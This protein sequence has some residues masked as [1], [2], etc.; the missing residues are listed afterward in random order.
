MTKPPV[1]LR[2]EDL[3]KEPYASILCYP[4]SEPEEVNKR[5]AELKK[6]GVTK[7]KFEDLGHTAGLPVVGK[8]YVGVVIVAYIGDKEYALKIRRTDTGR[9]DLNHEG[10]ML[11]KANS[12]GVGPTLISAS[13]NFMIS[14]FIGGGTLEMWMSNNKDANKI[15][16]VLTDV[17]EQC[18][19]LD[20]A[21][22]DHGE[23]SKAHKHILMDND[24]KPFMIDFE[25]ASTERR[26][27]NV[28]AIC[29]YLFLSNSAV[30]KIITEVMGQRNKQEITN[31]VQEYK[32]RPSEDTFAD[33]LRISL[34]AAVS[35]D[36]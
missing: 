35:K 15:R 12:A 10:E 22:I 8:G 2:I 26:T 21:G 32:R 14:T 4:R 17:M 36:G 24:G 33:L 1:T 29:Q 25:T 30:S 6:L 16:S 7:A 27:T 3:H 11:K 9:E 13:E 20:N 34:A 5:I 19:R 28:S 18:R 23:I 31:A